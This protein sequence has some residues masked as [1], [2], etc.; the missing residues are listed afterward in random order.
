MLVLNLC[1]SCECCIKFSGDNNPSRVHEF[2]DAL[3]EAIRRSLQDVASKKQESTPAA[4]LQATVDTTNTLV[5]EERPCR[6]TTMAV[7]EDAAPQVI[8]EPA[9]AVID[10][11]VE[12]AQMTV[13][14]DTAAVG[15]SQELRSSLEDLSSLANEMH[16]W[17]LSVD[18]Q[19]AT[20]DLVVD[21]KQTTTLENLKEESGFEETRP[22]CEF[23]DDAVSRL[24]AHLAMTRAEALYQDHDDNSDVSEA[25]I[26]SSDG[27]I[28]MKFEPPNSPR[29]SSKH[30]DAEESFASDAVGSGDVAEAMGATLDMVADMITEMLSEADAHNDVTCDDDTDSD[31]DA[32]SSHGLILESVKVT[33]SNANNDVA[34]ECD[35]WDLV[36]TESEHKDQSP[37][38]KDEDIARAAEMLGSALFNSDMKSS[39]EA[40]SALSNSI[41]S[42]PDSCSAVSSVPS[43]LPSLSSGAS[44]SAA[45]NA[46]PSCWAGH[47]EQLYE[48]GFENTDK[49]VE[50]L[51]RMAA[52]R[53]AAGSDEVVTVTQVVDE[54]LKQYETP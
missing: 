28:V 9:T 6:S 41:T 52:A 5:E 8:S 42:F 19:T 47:L 4:K 35:S 18:A 15:T 32:S 43:I 49:S 29:C 23:N 44:V 17:E 3:K 36:S 50:I 31:G 30:R 34:S 48:L 12:E 22:G 33:G 25:L 14:K 13:V 53:I 21:V 2:D 20:E 54:L 16:P 27:S 11:D 24:N 7:E 45:R 1:D 38:S 37:S 51:E 26:V 40:I 10:V 46:L 39:A